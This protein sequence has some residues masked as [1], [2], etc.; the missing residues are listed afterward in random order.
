MGGWLDKRTNH[1]VSV[2]F[3]EDCVQADASTEEP[4]RSTSSY[5]L[6]RGM[7]PYLEA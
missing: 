5:P 1:E 4:V 7:I 2:A 6:Y 3:E